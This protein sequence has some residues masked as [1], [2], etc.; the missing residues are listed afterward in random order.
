MTASDGGVI[1]VGGTAS[2]VGRKS[3]TIVY[4][5]TKKEVDDITVKIT[6]CLAH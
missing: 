2:T 3:S 5:S 4:C 6:K 1:G